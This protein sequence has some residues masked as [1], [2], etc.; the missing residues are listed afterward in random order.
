M[1]I[2]IDLEKNKRPVGE[3]VE[4]TLEGA[5]V[6]F[7]KGDRPVAKLVRIQTGP[8]RQFGSAKGLI[9]M[10]E[11]FDEPLDDFRELIS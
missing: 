8:R 5:E 9:E 10:T 2:T 3:L 11:D 4:Q 7:T 6:V 1:T